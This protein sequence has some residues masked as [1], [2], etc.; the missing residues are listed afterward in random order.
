MDGRIFC[1]QWG[2]VRGC[3]TRCRAWRWMW[4][5][6]SHWLS[7]WTPQCWRTIRTSTQCCVS[8]PRAAWCRPS[9][10]AVGH[11]Q[12]TITFTTDWQH[13]STRIS[14][15]RSAGEMMMMMMISGVNPGKNLGVSPFLPSLSSFLSH[16]SNPFP[17]VYNVPKIG[18]VRTPST[19]MDWRLWWCWWWWWWCGFCF[20]FVAQWSSA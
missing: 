15:R 17:F 20:Q 8:S 7:R 6:A 10:S 12:P 4:A 18:G 1:R 3:V 5:Q 11:S 13:P 16:P 14:P 2:D 9:T 19:P